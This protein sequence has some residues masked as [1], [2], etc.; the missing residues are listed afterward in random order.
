M[1]VRFLDTN[2]LLRYVPVMMKPRLRR[3][4]ISF[5]D[6]YNAHYAQSRGIVESYS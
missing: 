2:I 6:I 3:H 5:A 4:L 1:P